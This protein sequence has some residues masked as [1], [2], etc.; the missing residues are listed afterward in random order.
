MRAQTVIFVQ[1]RAFRQEVNI[2]IAQH[3][4]EA[5]SIFRIIGIAVPQVN[6]QTVFE[7]LP[8][9]GEFVLEKTGAV[10]AFHLR[11]DFPGVV[12]QDV[13]VLRLRLKCTHHQRVVHMTP[14]HAQNGERVSITGRNESFNDSLIQIILHYLLS[15][16][17]ST[18]RAMP[19]T[20]IATQSGRLETS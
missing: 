7:E 18:K 14:V 12:F 13:N 9:R 1:M 5:V 17:R 15:P 16:S 6:P 19:F 10:D 2:H 20:G 8:V 3:R 11:H 4:A